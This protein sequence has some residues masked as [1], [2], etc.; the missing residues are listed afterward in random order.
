MRIIG[1]KYRGRVLAGFKGND[2]RPT[3]D[4]VK[5]SLFNILAP[6]IHGANML[7]LFC[8]CGNV[9]LEALSRGADYVVFNDVSKE[10]LA[11]LK[12][13]LS[14]LKTDARVYNS[15]FK[16]LLETLDMTFD[17]IF[18]DPPYKSEY[19]V[20]ALRLIGERKLLTTGGVAVFE[21]DKP[22]TEELGSLVKYDERKYGKTYLTFFSPD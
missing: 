2:I 20:Q 1:G 6:E 10:S 19:G 11:V 13:N 5:E 21:S 8:G 9:G 18:I 12:K 14:L 17:I 3:A 7:D 22:F 16:T 4:R 15:D